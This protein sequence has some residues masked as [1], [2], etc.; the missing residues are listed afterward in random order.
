M[1]AFYASVEVL[2]HPEWKG[3]P[4]V[5]GGSPEGRGVIA[6][7]SYEARKFGIRSAMSSAQAVRLCPHAIF[8]RPR[9]SR[10]SEISD[11]VFAILHEAT[12]RV[13]P[14]SIDEAYL[15]VTVNKWNEPMAGKVAQRLRALIQERTGLTA[16]AGVAPNKF[17]AK[18]ASDLKKPNGLVIIPPARVD[19]VIAWLPVEKLW[20][21]GPVTAAKLKNLGIQTAAQL[22]EYDYAKLE[23]AVGSFAEFLVNLSKGIDPREVETNFEAKSRGSET[24]FSKDTREWGYL[25]DTLRELS[26][27]VAADLREHAHRGRTITLKVRFADF[28]TVTRS[29]TLPFHTSETSEIESVALRLLERELDTDLRAVRL[30]GVSVKG[31]LNADEPEQLRLPFPANDLW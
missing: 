28:S 10:Y 6:A 16:S 18:I 3:K 29:R 15:D 22:R 11:Q 8:A 21:V 7:A 25:A 13:E 14:L 1:D 20:G 12:D 5:V 31:F 9:F 19:S 17:L 23:S 27:E 4:V 30:L 24:T 2:D 26:T